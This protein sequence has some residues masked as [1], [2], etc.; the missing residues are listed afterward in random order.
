MSRRWKITITVKFLKTSVKD[1]RGHRASQLG[2]VSGH[3][4]MTWREPGQD[5]AVLAEGSAHVWMSSGGKQDLDV[6]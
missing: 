3:E 6:T 4:N 5:L 1:Q 2:R